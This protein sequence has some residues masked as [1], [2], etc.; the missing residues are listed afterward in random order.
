AEGSFADGLR[1]RG[2]PV[3]RRGSTPIELLDRLGVLGAKP[4]LIHCV[5]A[6]DEDIA[7]IVTSR[8]SVAHCPAS[9]AKLGH[10]IAPL[11]EMLAAG[12]TVGLGSDSMASNNRMD[13]LG[14]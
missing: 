4:L 2:I 7:R 5:R 1:R 9:N 11:D 12:V 14:E 10:G 13:I 8:S 3:E 6:S